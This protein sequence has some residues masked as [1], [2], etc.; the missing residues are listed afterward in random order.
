MRARACVYGQFNNSGGGRNLHLR[1][2]W[3]IFESEWDHATR[4]KGFAVSM[5]ADMIHGNMV[6]RSNFAH[7]RCD[8]ARKRKWLLGH[9]R[10]C[11][12]T[13]NYNSPRPWLPGTRSA[14]LDKQLLSLFCH[15]LYETVG[16]K[17][18]VIEEKFS[19]IAGLVLRTFRKM[20]AVIRAMPFSLNRGRALEKV[21]IFMWFASML[22]NFRAMAV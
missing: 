7:R 21:R 17:L 10:Q 22:P 1:S 9:S 15:K 3:N 18:I 13:T 5:D 14:S 11:W 19:E 4:P 12:K 20:L 16:I 2:R 6:I 8:A